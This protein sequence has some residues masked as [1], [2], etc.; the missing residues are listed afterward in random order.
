V[1]LDPNSTIELTTEYD[2]I[3]LVTTDSD[4]TISEHKLLPNYPNP[5]NPA[6]TIEYQ[7]SQNTQV[8]LEVYDVSGR[9]V[10]VLANDTRPAGHYSA[11]FDGS[12]LASGMYMVRFQADNEVQIRKITLIK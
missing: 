6:T 10:Q 9:R 12:N 1:S 11:E 8:L 5:F 7:L 3:A 2:E 4:E